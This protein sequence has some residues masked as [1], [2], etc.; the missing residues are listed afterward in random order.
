MLTRN[1]EG[2]FSRFILKNNNGINDARCVN[3]N[4][5]TTLKPDRLQNEMDIQNH[6][7]SHNYHPIYCSANQ[8]ITSISLKHITLKI[9]NMVLDIKVL[10][11]SN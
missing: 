8:P 7:W 3:V 9:V 5:L 1:K 11:F 10:D 2:S 6:F 4:W